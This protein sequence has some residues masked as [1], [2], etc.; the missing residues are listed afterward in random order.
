LR[1]VMIIRR[2]R[3]AA[4]GYSGSALRC[5]LRKPDLAASRNRTSA[6]YR[7]IGVTGLADLVHILKKLH[8]LGCMRERPNGSET[9]QGFD[10]LFSPS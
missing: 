7:A 4:T 2:T 1:A 5:D 3:P 8:G 10:A 6:T 9:E